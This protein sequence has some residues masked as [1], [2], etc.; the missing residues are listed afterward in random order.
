MSIENHIVSYELARELEK[1][2]L[3]R[4]SQFSYVYHKA[5]DTWRIENEENVYK[6]NYRKTIP[7][8]LATELLE[9]LPEGLVF[10]VNE[11]YKVWYRLKIDIC[12]T[13]NLQKHQERV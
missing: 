7:A 8:Y 9:L 11:K 1:R 5:R 12:R 3:K 2:G 4:E 13:K 10:P 6:Y